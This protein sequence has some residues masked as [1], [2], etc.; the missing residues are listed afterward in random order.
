MTHSESLLLSASLDGELTAQEQAQLDAHLPACAECSRELA[1]LRF[2]KTLLSAAPRRALP[3]EL[4]AATLARVDSRWAWLRDLARPVVL[5]PAGA[6]AAA[7][8]VVGV[9][10]NTTRHSTDQEIPLEPL[11]AAHERYTAEALIPSDNL[12]AGAYSRQLNDYYSSGDA[13]EPGQE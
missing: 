9:W 3:P 13:S 11:L 4:L 10:F 6:L 5:V 12:V 7:A 1:E 8:L 2:A